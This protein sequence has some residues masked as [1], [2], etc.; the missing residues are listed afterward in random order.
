MEEY[1]L[2]VVCSWIGNS[3]PVAMRHYLQVRDEHF[4]RAACVPVATDANSNPNRDPSVVQ[5]S[6]QH[7]GDN[8][9]NERKSVRGMNE[10]CLDSPLVSRPVPGNAPNRIA[11]EGLEPPTRGL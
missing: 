10:N 9:G 8:V 6:V 4:A 7:I 11:V 1:H 3:E 5:M 2:H